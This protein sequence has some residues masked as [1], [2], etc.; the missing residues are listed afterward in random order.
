M[1]QLFA[2]WPTCLY[3]CA[4]NWKASTY[5]LNNTS[6]NKIKKLS[7]THLIE[8]IPFFLFFWKILWSDFYVA[9]FRFFLSVCE[10]YQDIE[11]TFLGLRIYCCDHI[12][13]IFTSQAK[14][15]HYPLLEATICRTQYVLLASLRTLKALRLN[16]RLTHIKNKMCFN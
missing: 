5:P 10:T 11:K 8:L 7:T 3:K 12:C 16:K 6:R 13:T 9:V 1:S 15:N 14:T 4:I 2:C